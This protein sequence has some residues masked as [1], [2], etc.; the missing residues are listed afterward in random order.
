MWCSS[1]ASDAVRT[2]SSSSR[3]LVQLFRRRSVRDC[4]R[5]ARTARL[6]SSSPPRA[7]SVP[8]IAEVL[9]AAGPVQPACQISLRVTNQQLFLDAMTC[10]HMDEM[11]GELMGNRLANPYTSPARKFSGHWPSSCFGEPTKMHV[12]TDE[13]ATGDIR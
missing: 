13:V 12:A 5:R 1:V 8:K 3:R 7:A 11:S 9:A 4:S 6:S 10:G 2:T